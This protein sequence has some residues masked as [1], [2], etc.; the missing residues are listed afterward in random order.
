[1]GKHKKSDHPTERQSRLKKTARFLLNDTPLAEILFITTFILIRWWNNSDFSYP[2]EVLIPIGA[3]AVL[4]TVVFYVYRAILGPGLAA[5]LASLAL[6]YLFYIFQFVESSSF[7]RFIEDLLPQG[8]STAFNRSLLLALILGIICG[9][10]AW[11]VNFIV[12]RLDFLKKVQPYKVLLFAIVFIFSIQLF[13]TGARLIELRHQLNYQYQAQVLNTSGGQAPTSK[14]DI[15]YLV[16]D[17]YTNAETLK[18][19]FGYDN[20]ALIS[21]LDDQGF[22]TRPNAY[23]N[24]PFT[25]S[26]IASTLTL[27]YFPELEKRFG[28]DG[29]WQS[30][31]P[32]R[33][34]LNNPPIAQIL[35]NYGYKFNQVSSWWDFTRI[36]IKAD[37]NPSQ[38]YRLR[39]FNKSFFLSDLQRDIFFKSVLSPWLK[40]GLVLGDYGVLKYDIDRNPVE[41]FDAQIASL[42]GIASRADRSVPQFNFAHILAPHPPYIF[43]ADGKSPNYDVESNDNGVDETVKYANELTYINKRLQNLILDIKQ[44]SPGAVIVLQADEGPYPKQFRGP[45]SPEDYYDPLELPQAQ[46]K[47][48]LGI[49]ASYYLPDTQAA[50][51]ATINSSV[52]VFRFV[53]NKYFGYSLDILPDCQLA[54][55]NKFNLYNYTAVNDRLTNGPLPAECRAYE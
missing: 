12:D 53:L 10:S 9:L 19:N 48:K 29:R 44:T 17:R 20:S 37:S 32:Y 8:L 25:M 43:D 33:S 49:I 46:M 47:Q 15:Y 27:S 4:V 22:A 26:S 18:D 36:G 31:A 2:S 54:T 42:K 40:K 23:S 51:V 21:F 24:Y 13:R 1:M 52:N 34:I 14:P 28:A 16:F 55:G 3:F 38:S 35:S 6:S 11:A 50:E 7:G 41:N 30:A 5:H 45:M 39:A